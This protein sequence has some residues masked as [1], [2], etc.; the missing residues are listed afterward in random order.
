MKILIRNYREKGYVWKDATWRDFTYYVDDE[1]Y[2]ETGFSTTEIL[3]V[4][5]DNRNGYVVCRH[6]NT[7]VRNDPAEIEKHY[8]EMEAKK[9]CAKCK[10]MRHYSDRTNVTVEYVRNEDGTYQRNETS[11]VKLGCTAGWLTQEVNTA[12][13]KKGCAYVQCRRQGVVEIRDTFVKYPGLFNKSITVDLLEANKCVNEGY[14]NGHFE[15]DMKLR[16]TLKACVNTA[17]VVDHFRFVKRGASYNIYYSDTYNKLFYADWGRYE[18]NMS[19]IMTEEKV[20][21]ILTKISK[22]YKEAETD[23]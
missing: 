8:A 12:A 11:T 18:E 20:Q 14:K 21:Q 1:D 7:L 19:D 9:D 2:G 22:L 6:C 13:A 16:G 3:A 23:E 5:D 17:G 15:Y 10:Y 4:K